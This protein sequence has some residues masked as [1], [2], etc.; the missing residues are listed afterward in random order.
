MNYYGDVDWGKLQK[1]DNW[2]SINKLIARKS[3]C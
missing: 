3:G 2:Y 1:A